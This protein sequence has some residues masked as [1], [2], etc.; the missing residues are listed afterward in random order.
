MCLPS[1]KFEYGKTYIKQ[2]LSHHF[3]QITFQKL[4]RTHQLDKN[5]QLTKLEQK[6]RV[7]IYAAAT[8]CYTAT[9]QVYF[10]HF[11]FETKLL[12]FE[13]TKAV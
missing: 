8:N 10:Y 7:K 2:I 4:Y 6:K 11:G 1:P 13:R 3:E 12:H 5:A 9:A